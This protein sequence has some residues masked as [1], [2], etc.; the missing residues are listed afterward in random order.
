M[1]GTWGLKTVN[2]WAHGGLLQ[3]C[4]LQWHQFHQSLVG[5]SED[6][7]LSSHQSLETL[8]KTT[9]NTWVWVNTYRYI[10]S[11]MNIHKSQLFWG[12]LGTRVLIHPHMTIMTNLRPYEIIWEYIWHINHI[13]QKPNIV[14]RPSRIPGSSLHHRIC[15]S[16]EIPSGLPINAPMAARNPRRFPARI[17]SVLQL[18][19]AISPSPQL[20][21]SGRAWRP[22]TRRR[23]TEDAPAWHWK[24]PTC[25]AKMRITMKNWGMK[26]PKNHWVAVSLPPNSSAM[27]KSAALWVSIF[28]GRFSLLRKPHSATSLLRQFGGVAHHS[29]HHGAS[30]GSGRCSPRCI[31]AHTQ[32]ECVG[33]AATVTNHQRRLRR[34][35]ATHGCSELG[36]FQ[37][38]CYGWVWLISPLRKDGGRQDQHKKTL[39][40]MHVFLKNANPNDLGSYFCLIL[41]NLDVLLILIL[42]SAD[43]KWFESDSVTQGEPKMS[44]S[45]KQTTFMLCLGTGK[46]IFNF[47][48]ESDLSLSRR[49]RFARKIGGLRFHGWPRVAQLFEAKRF[50]A[51]Q[52]NAPHALPTTSDYQWLLTPSDYY[53]AWTGCPSCTLIHPALASARFKPRPAS[54]TDISRG[55]ISCAAPAA[56]HHLAWLGKDGSGKPG[57][58]LWGFFPCP[59]EQ[60]LKARLFPLSNGLSGAEAQFKQAE[61][62][63][64]VGLK[65]WRRSCRCLEDLFRMLSSNLLAQL[66]TL[67]SRPITSTSRVIPQVLSAKNTCFYWLLM[68]T[69]HV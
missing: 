19:V 31:G 50:P 44:T 4:F 42:L 51:L 46:R 61:S 62:A 6:H 2:P 18:G 69:H 1:D 58:Q 48:E 16:M 7:R 35:V 14:G 53:R 15:T 49:S 54:A 52:R 23:R 57:W 68:P 25:D 30:H 43:L 27:N 8:W 64:A 3:R 55:E 32:R 38:A 47:L 66:A 22:G 67:C 13:T 24:W 17:A 36:R 26:L 37:M 11:G 12:S 33:A 39:F 40:C 21:A 5:S 41:D 63:L 45:Q 10:F 29:R 60:N 56:G 28:S 20:R 9:E 65:I 59:L 34:K